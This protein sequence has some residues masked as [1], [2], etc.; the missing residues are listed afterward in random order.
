MLESVKRAY[1]KGLLIHAN[2]AR[3]RD[4]QNNELDFPVSLQV[5]ETYMQILM[6]AYRLSLSLQS[7]N[8]SIAD[9]LPG[10]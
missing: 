9:V 5:I 4:E 10:K 8:S 2:D 6:P 7:V 3:E 1:D